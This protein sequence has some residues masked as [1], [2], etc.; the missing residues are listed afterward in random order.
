QPLHP[1]IRALSPI[2]PHVLVLIFQ[3]R[4]F[5]AQNHLVFGAAH[6]LR[7]AFGFEEAE[8]DLPTNYFPE[9]RRSTAQKDARERSVEGFCF[10]GEQPN[11]PPDWALRS[12]RVEEAWAFSIA[13]KR[14]DRGAGIVIAQPDTG[15]TDHPELKGVARVSPRDIL[16]SDDDPTD[17]L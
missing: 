11:L 3:D 16:D 2:D 5:A 15:V 17:P 14:P 12:M 6:Q 10:T 9:K 1:V 8:P 13:K 4:V 7:D